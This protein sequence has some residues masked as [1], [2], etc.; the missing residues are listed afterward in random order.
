M[1]VPSSFLTI[2]WVPSVIQNETEG[3]KK[4][5]NLDGL[6]ISFRKFL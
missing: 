5:L 2:I 3:A 1:E 6:L 4:Y